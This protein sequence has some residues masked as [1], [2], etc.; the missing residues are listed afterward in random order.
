MV[1]RVMVG[2]FCTLAGGTVRLECEPLRVLAMRVTHVIA[3]QVMC[4][5]VRANTLGPTGKAFLSQLSRGTTTQ[6][7]ECHVSNTHSSLKPPG[8]VGRE[9]IGS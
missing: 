3:S 7:T 9:A 5:S 6:M 2:F 8:L 4:K 1:L